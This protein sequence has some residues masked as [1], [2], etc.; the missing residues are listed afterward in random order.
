VHFLYLSRKVSDHPAEEDEVLAREGK[1][2]EIAEN[3]FRW[4]AGVGCANGG[5]GRS[6][7]G[8]GGEKNGFVPFVGER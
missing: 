3:K 4:R 6:G 2:Y 8:G 5:K 1:K 7:R